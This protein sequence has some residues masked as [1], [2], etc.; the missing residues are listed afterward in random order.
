MAPEAEAHAQQ[1]LA[2]A[3]AVDALPDYLAQDAYLDELLRRNPVH[4]LDPFNEDVLPPTPPT[5]DDDFAP[6]ADHLDGLV[7]ALV[8]AAADEEMANLANGQGG[9]QPAVAAAAA[10]PA[11]AHDD[12]DGM[13]PLEDA[14]RFRDP[15]FDDELADWQINDE[16]PLEELFG[17]VGPLGH[18]FD[19]LVWITIFNGIAI[20]MFAFIP[21]VIGSAHVGLLTDWP[22]QSTAI[23]AG[24]G[25]FYVIA[26]AFLYLS[27]KNP[28]QQSLTSRILTFFS[29]FIKVCTLLV[30]EVVICPLLS[31][32]WLDVCSLELQNSTLRDHKAFFYSHT[33]TSSFLHWFVGMLFMHNFAGFVGVMRDVL[34]PGVLWF[35]RDP[36]DPAFHPL[37]QML[38]L[39]LATY[40]RRLLL[41]T[42]MYGNFD[43]ILDHFSQCSQLSIPW[44]PPHTHTHTQTPPRVP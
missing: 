36:N 32:W 11:N 38:E 24:V 44:S 21:C 3:P 26:A 41:I 1:P 13:P 43:I 42:I 12:L 23:S 27:I 8:A 17:L 40:S 4:D 34:R 10:L 16:V 15:D 18:L 25:Y 5:P 28:A 22:V 31:G 9:Q 2:P 30:C 29:V 14:D 37:K 19:N 6:A 33:W 39:P 7:E 35:F 20:F